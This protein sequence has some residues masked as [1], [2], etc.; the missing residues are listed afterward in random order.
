MTRLFRRLRAALCFIVFGGTVGALCRSFGVAAK[1]LGY[2]CLVGWVAMAGVIL[3]VGLI[4]PVWEKAGQ[5][6]P[7][8]Q[9]RRARTVTGTPATA[10]AK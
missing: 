10:D 5:P 4:V 3:V 6:S 8:R 9:R 2:W 1:T 7:T